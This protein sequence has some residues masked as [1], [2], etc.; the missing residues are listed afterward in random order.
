MQR[1]KITVL[2]VSDKS[3]YLRDERFDCWT[4]KRDVTNF[5]DMSPVIAH[6]PC[7]LWGR[8]RSLSTADKSE[9]LLAVSSVAHIR[10]FGGVLEHPA[11]SK[12]WSECGLPIPGQG[13]D[14][15]GGFSISIN[16]SWF[17]YPA[18]KNTWLYING[19]TVSELPPLPLNFNVITHVVS[20]SKKKTGKKELSKMRRD[21]TYPDLIN[22]LYSVMVTINFNKKI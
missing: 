12:L 6:P 2:F 5:C 4:K 17:G 8:L 15:F 9:K 7:R 11:G 3:Y 1:P 18:V 14:I 13:Y 16:Q 21:L 10:V 22:W 19:C 20:S